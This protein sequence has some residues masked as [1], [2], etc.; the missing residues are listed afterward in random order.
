MRRD[1]FGFFW[2]DTPAP[3][4]KGVKVLVNRPLPAIPETGWK[5][6]K[7]FPRL[8][9]A[10]VIGLDTETKD[11][12]LL[13]KGPG[14]RRP[15]CHIVGVSLSADGERSWYFP[16]R[17]E[18]ETENNMDPDTVLR[19]V[20]DVLADKRQTKI[21]TNLLYDLDWLA[22]SDV[23]AAGTLI[24][25]QV[26][27]ALL[28]ENANGYDLDSMGER[29]LGKGKESSVLQKWA[30]RAYDGAYRSN[31]YRCPP[32]L[33][34]PYAEADAVLPVQIHAKQMPRIH[35]EGLTRV[36]EVEVKLIRMLLGM[37]R[38]GVRVDLKHAARVE[39]RL[40]GLLEEE[41]AKLD[42]E[43]G[44]GVNVDAKE[45]LIKVFDAKSLS[46]P[47]TP[48]STRFPQGQPSFVKDFLEHHEHPIA[49]Q[50]VSIRKWTKFRDVFIRSYIYD[51]HVNGR[52]HCLF[53]QLRT[54]EYGTVSGRFSS[55]LP[56]LQNIPTRDKLWGPLI[57]SIFLPDA[58]EQWGKLD[59][60]QIEYRILVHRGKGPSADE[61]RRRYNEDADTD[62]HAWV[63]EI[64]SK[65][66]PIDR[67]KGKTIDFGLVYGMGTELLAS[68][69]GL[70]PAQAEPIFQ[71]YHKEVPFV[72][73]LA[74]A[75]THLAGQQGYIT[76]L[77]G[78]RRRF[79][80]WEPRYSDNNDDRQAFPM[81]IALAKWGPRLRRAYTHKSLNGDIQ[82]SAADL[83]KLAM[84][85]YME[86]GGILDA[87]GYPT[88]TVHDEL[89][90]SVP[91]TR[92]AKEAMLELQHMMETCLPLSV[93]IR[94][95]MK[96]G[97]NWGA[98]G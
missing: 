54:D 23:E 73:E 30:E 25:I 51:M 48:P 80:L 68:Q 41:Q 45:H 60:S 43:A 89:D 17:H 33:V 29:H 56:N 38:R 22:G 27:E 4:E 67:D 82:G 44:F 81:Q 92:A 5:P 76:T 13:T 57:R 2:D 77:L 3:K 93:P 36:W 70:T 31:I 74:K 87:L 7:E 86:T 21:G 42:H 16:I 55:S 72:R 14:V 39:A 40:E 37:R 83:M 75:M 32:S 88:L 79:D 49:K 71:A 18:L 61:A 94:A 63:A 11:P 47:F 10:K 78:R 53:N 58:G 20:G 52:I 8:D 34:G 90:E 9:S 15:G 62:F 59:W 1:G 84:S 35:A 12:D 50:I 24:D 66:T 91:R 95:D 85:L 64:V 69:L 65:V 98:L 26:A 28:D 46:Y 19:W 97:K 6:P 96:M